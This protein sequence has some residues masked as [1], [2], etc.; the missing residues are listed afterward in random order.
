MKRYIII[1]KHVGETPLSAMEA[2]RAREGMS[3]DIPLAYA[4][5]LDP[6]A[7]G[8]LL[9]LI[10][11]ECKRQEHYHAFDKEYVFEILF[12]FA[13]DT[14]DVLGMADAAGKT[15]AEHASKAPTAPELRR[16]LRTF[17]GTHPF[18][19][20][21]FSAKTVRGIPLHEW[22]LRGDLPDSEVPTYTA[23]IKSIRLNNL[24]EESGAD[25][26]KNM[27]A[28]I[29]LIPPVIDPRKALGADFRRGDIIPRW[30]SLL[31][32]PETMYS[33]ATVT[34]TVGSGTYIRSLAPAI[35]EA[36]GTYGLAYSI[37]RTKIGTYLPLPLGTGIWLKTFR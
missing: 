7:S 19:Y 13:S 8:Q 33:I 23:N 27:L 25:I 9:V 30:H 2:W 29:D 15:D 32:N 20:P 31:D 10:G 3:C 35:A 1:E 12:G 26:L 22:T 11:E 6:M 24:R 36:L 5:R 18:P 37:H 4:G 34:A 17:L 16:A 14:G 21:R 28:R